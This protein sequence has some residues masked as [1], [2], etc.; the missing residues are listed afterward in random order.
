MTYDLND[1]DLRTML[2][3]ITAS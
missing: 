1:L 3:V 2:T